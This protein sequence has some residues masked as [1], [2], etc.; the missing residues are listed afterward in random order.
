MERANQAK[1][2]NLAYSE[3][4][5]VEDFRAQ[6]RAEIKQYGSYYGFRN[7]YPYR[8]FVAASYVESAC[9]N[10]SVWQN[11]DRKTRGETEVPVY[12]SLWF[13]ER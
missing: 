12:K 13:Y 8:R 2:L 5:S 10:L 4:S 6:Q 11:E 3:G 1:A 9:R 7:V